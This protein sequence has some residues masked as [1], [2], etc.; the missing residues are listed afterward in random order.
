MRPL[1]EITTIIH[2]EKYPRRI[3]ALEE[4]EVMNMLNIVQNN[5]TLF[6]ILQPLQ[7]QTVTGIDKCCAFSY[8]GEGPTLCNTEF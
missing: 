2:F 6:K 3:I 5:K 1:E 8:G 4:I 7:D